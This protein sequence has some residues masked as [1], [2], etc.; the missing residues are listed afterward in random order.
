MDKWLNRVTDNKSTSEN[1]PVSSASKLESASQDVNNPMKIRKC[2]RKYD[3][4][5]I[6]IGF[7]V[8]DVSNEPRT[9]CVTCFKI[10]SNQ[11]MKPSLLKRH[12]STKHSTLENKPKDYFVRK[13]SEMK[14]TKKI[15]SS[16]SGSTEK[17]VE[18]SFL[19]S[20][21]IAKCGKPYTIGEELILPAA[22]DMV[23]CMLGYP[24]AKQLDMISLSNDT[25]RRRIESMA[26]NVKEKLIDQVKNS[27]FFS[28]QLDE[29]TDVSNYAQL[30]VYVRYV[31]QTVIKEDFLFC[32]A[33]S[34][35]TTADEIFKKLNHFFVEN[36][37]NWK[38]CVGFCSD[39]ARAMTGKH[40]GVASKIK[41][42]TENCTFIH[43]SIHREAL[44]VKRMPEQFKL[45]LQ[46]AI[47]VVNFI[48]SRALQSR[49][50]TKLCS[51]M[52]SDHIQLLLHTE[53]RWLSRG[54]ML[55]RLFE[56]HS[57]VQLF[58]GETN[59]ELKDKL[60]D[61]LWITTLAYL[62]DIFNCLNVL[63]LSL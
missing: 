28:I 23:T 55:S 11:C 1:C 44:V 53:V 27:D 9:Q 33:L 25:V 24:S 36:G 48:K 57:E 46:E 19:V 49:L 39:G 17:A 41:L 54:R 22:K 58:L 62:S 30:M 51:E 10:L 20:L 7:T 37:L 60:T 40:G 45:V 61:N 47:K 12:L 8:I 13:L 43:C 6:N 34:T 31:F 52:G 35:R 15:I 5:Y 42:V 59:F 50:F 56:L 32:E 4:D 14:S 3:P 63:N 26:L 21:R 16:F 2:L 29:S 18:A 38:K